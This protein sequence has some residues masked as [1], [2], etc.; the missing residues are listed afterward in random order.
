MGVDGWWLVAG[1]LPCLTLLWMEGVLVH[2]SVGGCVGRL[3]GCLST[4]G[5]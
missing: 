2:G 5:L 4:A 3:C 1:D